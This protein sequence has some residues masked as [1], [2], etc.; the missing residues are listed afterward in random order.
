MKA[1]VCTIVAKNYL[2]QARVLMESVRLSNPD[3]LRIVV[4]VDRIDGYFDP[5]KEPFDL[6]L[7]EDLAIP[8]SRWFHFKYPV[9]ELSTAVKPYALDLLFRRYELDKL[10]YLDPDIK[11]YATLQPLL[12]TLDRY[13]IALTPHLLHPLDD[14]FHPGELDILRCGAYN[15][16]FI[17]L[18]S[19]PETHRFLDW[20][21]KKLYDL[22]LVDLPRG[23]FVDQGWM[24]LAPCLFSQVG[25]IRD[26][27]YNV[28][29]W[30]LSSRQIGCIENSFTVNG[31]PL[32]FFH[33]S[34]F[35]PRNP[36]EFSRHQNRFRFSSLGPETKAL[37]LQYR[38]DVLAAGF[39]E[40]RKW[41]Y[42]YGRFANGLPIADKSRSIHHESR[43]L[44]ELLED[45]FS[46]EG[47]WS[48]VDSANQ[49]IAKEIKRIKKPT[50]PVWIRAEWEK[51]EQLNQLVAGEGKLKLTRLA[52]IIYETRPE[53]QR[54]FPDPCGRDSV[55]FLT[56]ILTY[57]KAEH[58][59]AKP[60][61]EPLR[62]QWNAVLDTPSARLWHR[63]L[64]AGMSTS[65]R[66]RKV[67]S[68]VSRGVGRVAHSMSDAVSSEIGLVKT[69]I[70]ARTRRSDRDEPR[71]DS[72]QARKIVGPLG[73][74]LVGYVRSEMGVGES[75]R[76]ASRSAKAVGLPVALRDIPTG[77]YRSEDHSAGPTANDFPY[78]F[79]VFHVNADQSRAVVGSLDPVFSESKYNIGFW[80]WEL[81]QFPDRWLPAF[82]PY[83]E[84]WTSSTFCQEAIARKSPI[85]VVQIPHS[86]SF[87]PP[88]RMGPAYF[89]LPQGRFSS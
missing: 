60:H 46:E 65:M 1:A 22:C 11:V 83:Q 41:P 58:H 26:P 51:P 47:F 78:A 76:A 16:G 62:S 43:K 88:P 64:L 13:S 15:L 7:S 31:E 85:P 82:D 34:G 8:R 32:Y 56:W 29:Y 49:P 54:S 72:V 19:G 70:R 37:A 74:N 61:L 36:G 2:A 79:N 57:G 55:R 9:L 68:A 89:G 75:S 24:D 45:P 67:G 18:S 77:D 52:Q 87:E 73:L 40:C 48:F 25:I 38:D 59:L 42:A 71:R 6:I 30:N 14:G 27:G 10:I 53:L 4:L 39:E 63:L 23:I 28:A 12:D 50:D 86:I 17:G 80:H 81:E 84:I 33:F 35:D 66:V 69:N 3:L 21:C 20:W 44:Q 5:A